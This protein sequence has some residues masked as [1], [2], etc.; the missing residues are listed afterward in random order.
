MADTVP[1]LKITAKALSH[2]RAAEAALA[3]VSAYSHTTRELDAAKASLT[4]CIELL[5][6]I[7][8]EAMALPVEA[9][10]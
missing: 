6:L 5:D 10:E 4:R 8:P 1:A 9:A 7:A 3:D 2:A